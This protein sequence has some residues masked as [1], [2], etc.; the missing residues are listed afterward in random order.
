[1][2]TNNVKG[3]FRTVLAVWHVL[4][5]FYIRLYTFSSTLSLSH[6]VVSI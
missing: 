3:E 1:M 2:V 6:S 4:N 5:I